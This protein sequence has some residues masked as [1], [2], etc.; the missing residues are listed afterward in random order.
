MAF[1][2]QNAK[3][4]LGIKLSTDKSSVSSLIW[5]L[6]YP[7]G[8][9]VQA[10]SF[11]LQISGYRPVFW[12]YSGYSRR[13]SEVIGNTEDC[14]DLHYHALSNRLFAALEEMK[15]ID[16]SGFLISEDTDL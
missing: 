5:C 15:T 3:S 11:A 13:W 14:E 12:F 7:H 8:I 9:S 2:M 4:N 16:G 10:A 6:R 1:T